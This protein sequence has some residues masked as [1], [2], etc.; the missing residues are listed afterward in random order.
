MKTLE[1]GLSA[2]FEITVSETDTAAHLGSGL[3]P[4]YA[5][6]SEWAQAHLPHPGLG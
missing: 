2:E 1:P 3:L 5:T 4:V 6:R